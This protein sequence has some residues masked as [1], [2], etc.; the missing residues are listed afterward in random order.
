MP[1]VAWQQHHSFC[2]GGQ[3]LLPRLQIT[4]QCV[5]QSRKGVKLTCA[6]GRWQG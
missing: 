5:A 6:D 3:E 1:T 2:L 4:S